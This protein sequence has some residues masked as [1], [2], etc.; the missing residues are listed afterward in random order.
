MQHILRREF[1]GRAA[2]LAAAGWALEH[3]HVLKA[4]PAAE[5]MFGKVKI[6][7]VQTA[8]I[9]INNPA[10]LVKITTDQGLFGIGE[11]YIGAGVLDNIAVLK[12]LVVGE[13]PLQV[14]YLLSR[15]LEGSSGHMGARASAISGIET[16]LWD[17]AGKVLN[18][19]AYVLL[20]GKFRQK[21]RVYHDTGAPRTADPQPW[22]EEAL[23]SKQYGFTAMKFD[24]NWESRGAGLMGKPYKYR[25]EAWNR[26]ISGLELSQWVRIVEEIVKALGPGYDLAIDCHWEYNTRDAL[27]LAQALEPLNIWFLEDPIPP[28]NA[29]ALARLT[30]ATKTP[31]C[32]GE[33]LDS[34]QQFRPFL[35]KQACDIIQPDPQRCAGLLETKR[36]ADMADLYYIPC[37]CHNMCT[38]VGTYATAHAC[39]S[40][41]SFVALESDSIEIPWWKDV[42]VN[43]GG[44]FYEGGYLTLSEKPGFGIELNEEVCKQHLATGS[45]WFGA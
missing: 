22:V 17:L 9:Q 32:M 31:I 34:R 25:R 43:N 12:R 6:R 21:I 33:N 44:K 10:H 16:A 19:P 15:M 18:V 28:D 24:I 20:G 38:P 45:K 36:I 26:S 3:S 40:M 5:S 7:D 41:R 29:D 1:L 37:A 23:R 14:D 39:M 4:M 8:T 11:A 42:V 27:R 30:A 35:E 2:G 13:D